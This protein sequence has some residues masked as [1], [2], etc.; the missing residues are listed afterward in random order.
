EPPARSTGRT[1]VADPEVPRGTRIG[2]W[3]VVGSIGRGGMGEVL[4][5]QRADGQYRMRAAL[6][7]LHEN[8][9]EHAERLARE[10]QIL[11]ALKHPH[12]AALID[13]GVDAAGHPWMV[14]EYVDGEPLDRWA[15]AQPLAT[16]LQVYMQIVAAVQHAHG[17]LVIHRDIKPSNILVD[18]HGHARLLDFGIA[19]L[20]SALH[21]RDRTQALATPNY[22]AP[23][24]LLGEPV[25][26][27]ADI[28]GLGA[29]LYAVLCG[30]PPLNL[31]D[32][33]LPIVVDRIR[34]QQP[35]PP[36]QVAPGIPA[37]L[38]AICL[39]CLAKAP[40][41][42]YDS[43]ASLLQDLTRHV[44]GF[45]VAARVP[46]PWD[47]LRHFVRRH[48][49]VASSAAMILLT[50]V[51]GMLITQHQAAVA[52]QERDA[53]R[54]EAL[55][56]S[57][58]RNAVTALF[59]KTIDA[60]AAL[61]ARELFVRTANDAQAR[62]SQ[63]PATSGALLQM[64]GHL[65]LQAEDYPAARALLERVVS[66]PRDQLAPSVLADAYLDL[67]HLDFRERNF[68]AVRDRLDAARTIWARQGTDQRNATLQLATLEA[69]LAR[70]EGRME[71]AIERLQSAITIARDYWGPEHPETASLL[72]NL[73]ATRYYAGDIR[74]AISS[75]AEAF[76]IY[77][78]LG[79]AQSPDALNLLANW[80]VYAL[81]AGR[82]VEAEQRLSQALD[83]RTE[84]YGASAAQAILMKNL[85]LAHLVNGRDRDGLDLLEQSQ[86]MAERYAGADSHVH[87][88]TTCTLG[89]VLLEHGQL[90]DAR[91]ALSRLSADAL[92]RDSHWADVCQ[93]L[94]TLSD[95][96]AADITAELNQLA[97]RGASR[98]VYRARLL[99]TKARLLQR[100]GQPTAALATYTAA[101]DEQRQARGAEHYET[102]Q[103]LLEQAL[104]QQQLADSA[105]ARRA[106]REARDRLARTLGPQHPLV[107]RY[108][109]LS[110]R[111]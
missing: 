89:Q 29:T 38:D 74:G 11:A 42:R 98:Q 103:L 111:S 36:S 93:A 70:A 52:V 94:L 18:E 108:T 4:E 23:E 76:E 71:D 41:D 81:R 48:R 40:A 77:Q 102:L 32:Q 88:S 95:D 47:H 45:P 86:W 107:T 82:P 79:K 57:G 22:A 66:L 59:Q 106:F 72:V 83:L 56:L 37:D 54:L 30:K 85:G 21:T 58:L 80:G 43:A 8:G 31:E 2:A 9:Q 63:D 20:L 1:E 65:Q 27:H 35:P 16:R 39:K 91:A 15:H 6:K 17:Q 26:V 100:A 55:R 99:A 101:V 73:G 92:R 90:K 12:I 19:K 53:A 68:P 67:A 78:A 14:L 96:P 7:R 109:E 87:W 84:L 44:D 50:L 34:H 97:S 28:Y 33:P 10:R 24:Q 104:V 13:G 3:E 5:V 61:T 25:A 110:P 60:D 49:V 51:G 64:L 62:L 105:T 75:S 69:Q 46:G